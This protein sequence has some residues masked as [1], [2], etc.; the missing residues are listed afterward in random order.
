MKTSRM[1]LLVVALTSLALFA[2]A[3]HPPASGGSGVPGAE[4]TVHKEAHPEEDHGTG[5]AEK[6]Y[7]GIPESILKVINLI[8][9]LLLLGYVLKGPLKKAFAERGGQIRTQL[10]EAAVR[11]EKADRFASDI[12]Q[13]LRA[14]EAEVTVILDRAQEDGERQK[15]ELIA[16]GEIEAARILTTARNEV[17]ARLKLARKELTDYA[18]ELATVRAREILERELTEEDRRRIFLENVDQLGGEVR[19]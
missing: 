16:A 7:F 5:H 17:N 15:N 1:F 14:L 3:Q 18:G 12:D 4:N 13:R 11:R 10:S 19:S 6:K 8:V 9:F 2:Y